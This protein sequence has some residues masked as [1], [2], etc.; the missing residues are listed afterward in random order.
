MIEDMN[1]QIVS[2]EMEN[3]F[4]DMIE[5]SKRLFKVECDP[6]KLWDLY[7]NTFTKDENKIYK[8]KGE[9]ECYECKRFIKK[10]GNVV[11]IKNNVLDTI[12]NF[13]SIYPTFNIINKTLDEY[14]RSCKKI[15]NVF[16]MS[17]KKNMGVHHN[18]YCKDYDNSKVTIFYH[19]YLHAPIITTLA[20]NELKLSDSYVLSNE[21][22]PNKIVFERALKEF[23][24]YAIRT[25]LSYCDNNL[26]TRGKENRE[27][28]KV[29]KDI[30]D[31][32]DKLSNDCDRELFVWENTVK[33]NVRVNRIRSSAIGKLLEDISKEVDIEKAVALYEKIV[34]KS[35]KKE[36]Q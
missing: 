25:V 35:S 27:T 10:Y 8:T 3:H 19:L 29:F 13:T 20:G 23:T 22:K 6:N 4:K 21:F 34:N 2:E 18:R 36:E 24:P 11:S 5:G 33:V 30:K 12:W 14:I 1:Y 16:L 17:Y 32:Y 31:R 28:I 7:I 15:D 9:Y 26:I